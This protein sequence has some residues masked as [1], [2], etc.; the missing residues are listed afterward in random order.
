[1]DSQ[2]HGALLS[3]ELDNQ[4]TRTRP[5]FGPRA[6]AQRAHGDL[7]RRLAG[8]AYSQESEGAHGAR[9]DDQRSREDRGLSEN[10]EEN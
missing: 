10:R 5:S 3:D 4:I 2:L 1:V 9:E 8:L 7:T 6:T